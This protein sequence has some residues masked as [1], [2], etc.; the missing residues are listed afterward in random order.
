MDRRVDADKP[1]PTF[2]GLGA[3]RTNED[4]YTIC[5]N[6]YK[7]TGHQVNRLLSKIYNIFLP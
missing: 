7:S 2:A 3:K 1:T 5:L 4:P 6:I